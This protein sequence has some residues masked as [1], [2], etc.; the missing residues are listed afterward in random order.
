MTI[1]SP[2][3]ISSIGQLTD[4]ELQSNYLNH[5]DRTTEIA[6]LL[7]QITDPDLALRIVNLALEVDL[8]LGAK[9]TAS[10]DPALQKVI[11]DRIDRLELPTTL[12]ISL[13]CKTKSKAALPCLQD[14]FIFKHRQSNNRDGERTISSVIGAI[15]CIDRDLAIALLIE[16][17]S[18]SRWYR[19]AAKHLARLAS[20]E[21]IELLAPLLKDKYLTS[22]WDS[23]HLAIEALERIGTDEAIN[24]IREVLED[25]SLWLQS[26]YIYVLGIVADPAMVEHLIYLLYEPELYIHRSTDYPES[27]E[28]YANEV[29]N[30]SYRAIDALERIGGN[31]VFDLLHRSMYW[32][33]NSGDGYTP[34]DKIVELLFKLDCDRTLTALE[35]A[36]QSYDPIVR[37]RAAKALAAWD[38]PI[39]DRNLSILLDALD[40]PDLDVQI[41]IVC[42]VR[43]IVDRSTSIYNPLNITSQLIDRAI[44]KTDRIIRKYI[45]YPDLEIRDR[46]ISQLSIREAY[47]W[48]TIDENKKS[49][50]LPTLST[51]L[52][53]PDLEIRRSAVTSIVKLG[54]AA[55]FSIVLEL[56]NISELVATLIWEL[57]QSHES[58]T[59]GEIFNE[60]HRD[61]EVT[62]KFLGTAENSLIDA[63]GEEDWCYSHKYSCIR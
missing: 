60:F 47:Q 37:V 16:D 26:P 45:N 52:D 61:R 59:V 3:T 39:C 11:V 55:V 2:L 20:E 1:Y 56:V 23:K 29:T 42:I 51:L 4:R 28:Y 63:I 22:E 31:K 19:N 21:E 46:V 54:S 33:S 30:L 14:I 7:T 32:I 12:K 36:I 25:R 6:T 40:D 17:L 43:Q 50:D 13:W 8:F 10:I 5:L 34:F 18:D 53:D 27:E 57:K 35:C 15:S 44:L 48:Q 9:L 38:I 58:E 62:T 49:N 41:K 24:K